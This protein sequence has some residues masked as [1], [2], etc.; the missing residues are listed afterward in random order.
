MENNPALLKSSMFGGFKKKDV[1]SYIFEL[2]EATQDEKQKLADQIEELAQS[3]ESLAAS[4]SEMEQK[5]AGLRSSL[6]DVD[7]RLKQEMR[8]NAEYEELIEKLKA[9]LK[10][11][12]STISK[13]NAELAGQTELNSRLAEKNRGYEEKRRQVELAASQIAGLL[14]QAKADADSIVDRARLE[15]E[16]IVWDA[17]ASVETH[18]AEANKTVDEAY[19]KF[20]DFRAEFEALNEKVAGAATSMTG[21]MQSLRDAISDIEKLVPEKLSAEALPALKYSK[22]SDAKSESQK[23]TNPVAVTAAAISS[24]SLEEEADS[25]TAS[26]LRRYG[27]RKD[28]SGFFR[29]ASE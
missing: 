9:E 4:A 21:K 13:Q 18:V 26:I 22:D 11:H 14:N 27:V 1:L 8:K 19:K 23:E 17:K 15:A 5:I 28:E 25:M 16:N 20:G 7:A 29:L 24:S 3:R 10:R 2:N 6:D 12:E